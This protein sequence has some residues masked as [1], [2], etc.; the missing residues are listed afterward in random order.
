MDSRHHA[1][2]VL[3][4]A[5]VGTVVSYFC[6]RQYYPS[7]VSPNSHLPFAPRFPATDKPGDADGAGIAMEEQ[8]TTQDA[9]AG[10]IRR[11]TGEDPAVPGTTPRETPVAAT[12]A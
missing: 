9:E 8:T 1:T 5:L 12:K 4:G 11:R 6:Y 2:D 10:G 7:L 3:F